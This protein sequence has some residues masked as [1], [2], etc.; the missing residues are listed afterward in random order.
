MVATSRPLCRSSWL[1]CTATSSR[2]T[3]RGS[4]HPTRRPDGQRRRPSAA[5]RR[6]VR[7]Q[8]PNPLQWVW[9]ALGG[10]LPRELSPWVLADTTGRTWILRHLGARRRPDAAGASSSACVA[11]PVPLAYRVSAAVGGLL[12][13]LMFSMAF[14]TETIEHRAAKA[15]YPPGR[16]PGCAPSGP[17]GSASSATPPTAGTAPAASTESRQLDAEADLHRDLEVGDVAVDDL[18][19]DLLGLEPL[20]VPD[21]L[22]RLA[23]RR[24]DRLVDARRAAAD[25]LAQPVHVVA[26]AASSL[27]VVP[28]PRPWHDRRI[29]ARASR[30]VRYA[31]RTYSPGGRRTYVSGRPEYV[32]RQISAPRSSRRLRG[33]PDDRRR[34]PRCPL[35][36]TPKPP[37]PHPGSPTEPSTG[38]PLARTWPPGTTPTW[39]ATVRRYEGLLRSSAR[40]VL[41]SDADVDEAV[42]RTWVLLLRNAARIHDPQRLPGWLSTTARREALAILRAQQRAVPTEDVADQVAPDDRDMA[43]ELMRQELRSAL[44]P[45]GGHP[46]GHPAA[47]GA[48]AAAAS[49]SPTTRSAASW[50]SRG[51]ASARCADGRSGPCARSWSRACAERTQVA[52]AAAR[53]AVVD[54]VLDALRGT[55]RPCVRSGVGVDDLRGAARRGSSSSSTVS[56]GSSPGAE[57]RQ[58][59]R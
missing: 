40:V 46:A 13:G 18:A 33:V 25:D 9:Y 31:A 5:Y 19:A 38:G 47:D 6:G 2:A 4:V 39:Q 59:D 12:L 43:A 16:P 35:S 23:D 21:G 41:R 14:M 11:V 51:A 28:E 55:P 44:R 56:S 58:L 29:A 30:T 49:R 32:V 3:V 20:D 8:R 50:G 34:S 36:P 42:Q 37:P 45:R 22:R 27:A 17:S 52:R 26:H 54:D 48:G 24:P 53:A 1:I 57:Q 10:G 7:A 15:G